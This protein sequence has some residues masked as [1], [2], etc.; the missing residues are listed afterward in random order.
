MNL[1]AITGTAIWMVLGGGFL[2]QIHSN[3]KDEKKDESVRIKTVAVRNESA[4]KSGNDLTEVSV[5]FD[6]LPVEPF[7]FGILIPQAQGSDTTSYPDGWHAMPHRAVV[8]WTTPA[9]KKVEV[10]VEVKAKVP[11]DFPTGGALVFAIHPDETVTLRFVPPK[12]R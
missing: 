3:E 6:T 9:K 7:T 5:W 10:S 4:K 8:A 11:Q 12:K 1:Q 2:M